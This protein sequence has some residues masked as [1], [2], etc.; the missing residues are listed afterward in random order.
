MLKRLFL[1]LLLTLAPV[2]AEPD[3]N[4]ILPRFRQ[5]CQ[6]ALKASGVPGCSV[7]VVYKGKVVMLEGFGVTNVDRPTPV[8]ADTVFHLASCS[9]PIATSAVAALVGE[10]KVS[11]DTLIAE[12]D[13]AFQLND[14]WVTSHLTVRDLLCHRSGLPGQAGNELEELGFD[15]ASILHNLR[16][17]PLDNR[18]RS[19]YSYS[20]FGI[21]AGCVAA[22]RGQ[23]DLVC[24]TKIFDP[25]GMK[26]TSTR[27]ADFARASDRAREH[28]LEDGKAVQR[29]DRMPDAQAPAGG[30]SSTARD[31]SRFLLLHL[32]E[33][34][35]DGKQIVAR[36]ALLA[37]HQ[38]LMVTGFNPATFSTGFYGLGWASS[39]NRHGMLEVKHSGAFSTGTRSQLLLIPEAELGIAILCNA[40]PS[41]LPEGLSSGLV[42]LVLDGKGSL[43]DVMATER[44]VGQGMAGMV[45]GGLSWSQRPAQGQAPVAA[46]AIEG[47]YD[48]AYFGP[49]RVAGMQLSFGPDL[50]VTAPL[51]PWD[52]STFYYE[53]DLKDG[54]LV[55]LVRFE[56]GPDGQATAFRLE[57]LDNWKT[58]RFARR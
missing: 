7:A 13:P 1:A 40:F 8:T 36:E 45:D 15:Q 10:Q 33:G 56:L 29:Y 37:T 20:N 22:T 48:N 49:A 54:P 44:K 3:M 46:Q 6:E 53:A 21:T 18:F 51:R 47:S 4:A 26:S 57:Q 24:K 5:L 11:F 28:I 32:G 38:P 27:Y 30:V 39:Y 9:K 31:L 25:L 17:V 55:T 34:T 14:P 12:L 19:S 16:E 50:R 52:G 41:G 58:A 2:A 23:F 43:E 35:V 42:S